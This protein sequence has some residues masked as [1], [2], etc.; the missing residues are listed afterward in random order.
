M[1]QHGIGNLFCNGRLVV[2][3]DEK[4]H[5][6][7]HIRELAGKMILL[8]FAIGDRYCFVPLLHRA[9]RTHICSAMAGT[10][11]IASLHHFTKY[12]AWNLQTKT[13]SKKLLPQTRNYCKRFRVTLA[14]LC[15]YGWIVQIFGGE[16]TGTGTTEHVSPSI[17][18]ISE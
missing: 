12:L 18:S 4:L 2:V 6:C 8:P 11:S 14:R 15:D 17:Q 10:T 5:T 7:K 3:A 16:E 13:R 9:L 1:A